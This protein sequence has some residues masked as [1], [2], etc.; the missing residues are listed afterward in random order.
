MRKGKAAPA[1]LDHDCVRLKCFQP[2]IPPVQ[3]LPSPCF[4]PGL[5]GRGKEEHSSSFCSLRPCSDPAQ[6]LPSLQGEVT[7]LPFTLKF[8]P[9]QAQTHV[10]HPF[11]VCSSTQ[12]PAGSR[13]SP[14][15]ECCSSGG[16]R[17]S[18][19]RA[20]GTRGI[21]LGKAGKVSGLHLET[22][23]SRQ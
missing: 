2:F 16:R 14:V 3:N 22:T 21:W 5:K 12:P 13:P 17:G 23:A 19:T 11:V 15:T 6:I 18:W 4:D 7:R 8:C 10:P 9:V 1:A 20:Q